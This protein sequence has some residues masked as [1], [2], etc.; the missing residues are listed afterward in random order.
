MKRFIGRPF[1]D[2]KVPQA[3]EHLSYAIEKDDQERPVI[4]VPQGGR[5][6]PE[7]ISALVLEEMRRIA[8]LHTGG[9]P[10][11]KAVVTVP[12][13][14][15]SSQKKA[16]EDACAIAGLKCL[17]IIN[18][19][20]AAALAYSE[21][22]D[23]LEADQKMILVFDFGGGTLDVT[24][25]S[26]DEGTIQVAATRG[27]PYLGGRDIDCAIVKHCIEQFNRDNRNVKLKGGVVM[28]K[29]QKLAEQAKI[30]LSKQDVARIQ[31]ENIMDAT[32][33]DVTMTKADFE[34][35]IDSI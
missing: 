30:T 22:I 26:V 13:Y 4:V 17:R 7:Q 9:R 18:E 31:A 20:T 19:P 23:L 21:Q 2:P 14:F 5:F 3:I 6:Y 34:Q 27:D 10:I 32:D 12:A 35:V 25:I 24:I 33:L 8:E 28:K 1:C 15:T 16:T 29:L 11:D